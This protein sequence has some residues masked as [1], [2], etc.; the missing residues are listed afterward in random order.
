V[1]ES[2]SKDLGGAREDG[3]KR[4]GFDSREAG[5]LPFKAVI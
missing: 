4:G 2:E 3:G 5:G 1:A